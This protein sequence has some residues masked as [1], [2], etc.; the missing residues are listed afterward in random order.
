MRRRQAFSHLQ[1]T[2]GKPKTKLQKLL[3]V[4]K[5]PKPVPEE[6]PAPPVMRPPTATEKGVCPKCEMYIGRGV[7][8]HVKACQG[9]ARRE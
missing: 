8:G 2:G 4:P 3:A 7:A 1:P 6:A 9:G 5:V